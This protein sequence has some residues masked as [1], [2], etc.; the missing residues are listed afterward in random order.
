MFLLMLVYFQVCSSEVTK[1]FKTYPLTKLQLKI[2]YHLE[3]TSLKS[4]MQILTIY[5]FWNK[6]SVIHSVQLSLYWIIISMNQQYQKWYWT[7]LK[8][9]L[10]GC[11]LRTAFLAIY[12]IQHKH[13]AEEESRRKKCGT[14]FFDIV[15]FNY[16]IK[17]IPMV[18]ILW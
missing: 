3:E 13:M 6:Y 17:Q 14:V 4:S 9:I 5:G 11:F 15:L 2:L 12:K 1:I 8:L 16:E 10:R 7:Y 18:P